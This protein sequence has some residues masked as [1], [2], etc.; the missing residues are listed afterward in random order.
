MPQK[1]VVTLDDKLVKDIIEE[2]YSKPYRQSTPLARTRTGRAIHTSIVDKLTLQLIGQE[3]APDAIPELTD[4]ITRDFMKSRIESGD[5][6]GILAAEAIG[7]PVTQ[8]ALGK[9]PTKKNLKG[10]TST[11]FELFQASR[12][13][14]S[15]TCS[16][17][18]K[19]TLSYFDVL[20]RSNRYIQVN[21]DSLVENAD[22]I[23][24][25]DPEYPT[26]W[27]RLQR[28]QYGSRFPVDAYV[29]RIK[30]DMVKVLKHS[31]TVEDIRDAIAREDE[32]N[33][34][35]MHSSQE[36]GVIDLIQ[37][38]TMVNNYEREMGIT[39][40][41]AKSF[42]MMTFLSGKIGEIQIKGMKKSRSFNSS[43]KNM[44]PAKINVY[45]FVRSESLVDEDYEG[46]LLWEL[47]WRADVA[48]RYGVKYDRF[49]WLCEHSGAKAFESDGKYYAW[50][51]KNPG[52]SPVALISSK[53]ESLD[54]AWKV[55]NKERLKN[56]HWR[57]KDLPEFVKHASVTYAEAEGSDYIAFVS[58]DDVDPYRTVPNNFTTIYYYLG[59]EAVRLLHILEFMDVIESTSYISNR[60]IV[61][62]AD[63]MTSRGGITALNQVGGGTITKAT[64]GE[65]MANVRKDATFKSVESLERGKVTSI[66]AVATGVPV[67]GGTAEIELMINEELTKDLP[68]VAEDPTDKEID[69]EINLILANR[70]GLDMPI[71]YTPSLKKNQVYTGV[72]MQPELPPIKVEEVT[73]KKVVQA[74]W[75]VD[76]SAMFKQAVSSTNKELSTLNMEIKNTIPEQKH[77]DLS[78]P[79]L[80]VPG[81][82]PLAPFVGFESLVRPLYPDKPYDLVVISDPKWGFKPLLSDM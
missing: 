64:K 68:P 65:A 1:D 77:I 72:E 2:G 11:L 28:L 32:P 8:A 35:I 20:A 40:V 3:I 18:F 66:A 34:A 31:L 13:R 22:I 47:S 9:D 43:V 42:S 5:Q 71:D 19:D 74:T 48:W 7:H 79:D 21:L 55:E 12:V 69:A 59:T 51:P 30:L 15:E 46:G 56:K 26:W 78:L 16:V 23:R 82:I 53:D 81:F 49:V 44:T 61:L 50:T 14:K 57:T 45:S 67:P 62:L 27:N 76:E 24:L 6:V 80:P 36:E 17:Y 39:T 38:I 63:V 58:D 33:L 60:H 54:E 10:G 25:S 73:K 37:I 75:K 29:L 4:A 52:M 70:D 41:E